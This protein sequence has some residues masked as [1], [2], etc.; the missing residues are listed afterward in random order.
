MN[1]PPSE[2]VYDLLRTTDYTKEP[3]GG[4]L[5]KVAAMG[6]QFEEDEENAARLSQGI[7]DNVTSIRRPGK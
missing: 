1:K 2:V 5:L 4:F 3:I 6:K 7:P